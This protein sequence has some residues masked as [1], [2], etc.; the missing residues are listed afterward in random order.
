M[1]ILVAED[2]NLYRTMLKRLLEEW[3]YEVVLA[4]NGYEGQRILDSN[5]SPR[6][7]ILDCLM[8]GMSGLELCEHIRARKQNYV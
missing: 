1:K 5:D 3:G 7:A 6:L 8:P 4:A 2:S